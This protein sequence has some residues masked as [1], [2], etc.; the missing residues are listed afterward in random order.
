VGF[1]ISF[2][3]PVRV[4]LSISLWRFWWCMPQDDIE[5]EPRVSPFAQCET[6]AL[7]RPTPLVPTFHAILTGLCSHDMP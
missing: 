7:E 2:L 1:A 6:L 5:M 3:T 4:V